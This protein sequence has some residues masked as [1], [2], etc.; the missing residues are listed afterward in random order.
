[1]S[2]AMPTT[3]LLD[4]LPV[5]TALGRMPDTV[6]GIAYDSRKVG[7]G[8]LF[9]AVPGLKQDGRRFVPEAVARGAGVVVVEGTDPLAGSDT[10]RVLVPSSR[11]A[12][13]RL[14][15]AYYGHPSRGLT[16]V[17]VTGTNGKTTSAF[18][19]EALLRAAGHRPGLIG[20]IE[21]RIGDMIEPAGQT[22][23]EAVELQSL[24]ARMRDAGVTGAAMEVS[25]HALALS[26]VTGTEFDV[27]VFTN[28][29]QDH[30]DFHGTMDEYR[31]AKA[32]L[33]TLLAGGRK[34]R[35][36]AV[37]NGDDP[38]GRSMVDG[39]ALRTLVFGLEGA[40]DVKPRRF[41][42]AMEGIRL[43]ADTPAGVVALDSRLVGEH[44]VMNLLGA[45]GVGVA[46]EMSPARIGEALASVRAV[47]GRFERVEAGQPFLVAVDYAHTPDALER[48]LTTARRLVT[49]GGRVGVVFGC[50]G[51]RDRGKRPIM[52]EIAVRLADRAW[53]TSDN[54]RTE[55]PAAIIDEI[56]AGIARAGVGR[57]RYTAIVDR[58]AA[59][60][61][62]LGWARAGDVL[63]IA[64]KGHE[65]YQIIGT[66][67]IAFD[68]RA[69][70]RRVLTGGTSP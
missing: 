21:Y 38:A 61:D 29:T 31:R 5:K 60:R 8:S 49:G 51:D 56:L 66:E 41:V 50:G 14:A 37:V 58:A 19:V 13:A 46:L 67:V 55:P 36:A 59:I 40:A 48:T 57:D 18:L 32:R 64:G 45:I 9:V 63:V 65:P 11:E 42:S 28:L 4:A 22:T 44:N 47:P 33:F 25:S 6:A 17:G 1:M 68:D 10:A 69:V 35:R 20:T 43:E 39:L 27:A 30:L 52:G 34:P 26:R 2:G 16:L 62:A 24:L 23:P 12:L 53:A 3:A 54:P 70:A 15:D 7:P